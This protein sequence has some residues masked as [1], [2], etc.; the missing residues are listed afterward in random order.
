MFRSLFQTKLHI[1]R[2][3]LRDNLGS[4]NFEMFIIW[5]NKVVIAIIFTPVVAVTSLFAKSGFIALLNI[6][7]SLCNIYDLARRFWYGVNS[8]TDTLLTILCLMTA[9]GIT[10]I[11]HTSGFFPALWTLQNVIYSST[12][13][14]TAINSLFSV[15]NVVIP[16]LKKLVDLIANVIGFKNYNSFLIKPLDLTIEKDKYVINRFLMRTFG[17]SHMYRCCDFN[18]SEVKLFNNMYRMLIKYLN[19][20]NESLFGNI[21]RQSDIN[22]IE[23]NI[24]ELTC[25]GEDNNTLRFLNKKRDFKET[26]ILELKYARRQLKQAARNY[27]IE[28]YNRLLV[29]YFRNPRKISIS[30]LGTQNLD[31]CSVIS[32]DDTSATIQIKNHEYISQTSIRCDTCTKQLVTTVWQRDK[33]IF[34]TEIARQQQKKEDLE[35]CLPQYFKRS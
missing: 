23:K 26:K 29:E 5:F 6:I 13:L 12:V 33:A 35:K 8:T 1:K 9:L 25:C 4:N 20:Y 27:D 22:L 32:D 30:K 34:D 11:M 14:A 21:I 10:V 7:L 28:T 16:L 31:S 24:N 18:Q 2:D 17:R 19:K 15:K 3:K